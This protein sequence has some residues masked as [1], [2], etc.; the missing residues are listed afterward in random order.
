MDN[1]ILCPKCKQLIRDIDASE[2][3]TITIRKKWN[4][5]KKK[6]FY[7]EKTVTGERETAL[8]CK[9]CGTKTII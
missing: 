2:S 8:Y 5:R 4:W 6:Y 1:R 7:H 9:K 3:K